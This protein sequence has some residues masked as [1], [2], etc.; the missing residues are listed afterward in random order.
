VLKIFQTH[1]PLAICL[2][3]AH[4]IGAL[5]TSKSFG[6]L[7]AQDEKGLWPVSGVKS[8]N[9]KQFLLLQLGDLQ[10]KHYSI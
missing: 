3:F 10:N 8:Y 7:K 4:L 5:H 6:D 2:R 9:G 1:L